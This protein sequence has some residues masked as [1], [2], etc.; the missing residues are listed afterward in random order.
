M[1]YRE[2]RW[3]CLLS[4]GIFFFFFIVPMLKMWLIFWLYH[5]IITIHL[6][7]SSCDKFIIISPFFFWKIAI[8]VAR[9]MHNLFNVSTKFSFRVSLMTSICTVYKTI[10]T[11]CSCGMQ[12]LSRRKE[13]HERVSR[14]LVSLGW[15]A[16]GFHG[17]VRAKKR[18]GWF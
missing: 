18:V 17:W 8:N 1:G 10:T 7:N 5:D 13:E 14:V 4:V 6:K 11:N 15:V 16:L 3:I 2:G 9:S 12:K